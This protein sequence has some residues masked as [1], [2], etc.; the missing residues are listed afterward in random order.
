MSFGYFRRAEMAD[1]KGFKTMVSTLGRYSRMTL[2]MMK[3]CLIREMQ[4]RSNFVIRL[5]TEV[6]WL[7]MQIVYV[8]VLYGVTQTIGGWNVWQMVML[9]GTNHILTQLFE[10]FFFDNCTKLV[11]QIRLGD[12]DFVLIK[13]VNPQ[14]LVSLRYTDYASMTNSLVGFAMIGYAIHRLGI[15]IT[16]LEAFLFLLLIVNGILIL[17]AMTF[18]LSV[19]TFWIGRASNL[20]E[21]YY[22]L[23]QFTRYPGEIYRWGLRIALLTVIPMLVVSN[24]PVKMLLGGL[25]NAWLGYA[26]AIG[27]TFFAATVWVWNL[28]L[29]RYRSA[30]S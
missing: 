13:P 1:S 29:R 9:L 17:Y 6:I 27:L 7:G 3:N 4:F 21:L 30:S 11:D 24:F 15:A 10:A 26:C 20:F 14:F 19:L 22:Q 28:G 18:C 2:L 16:P 8:A 12:L 5:F 23:T 25:F